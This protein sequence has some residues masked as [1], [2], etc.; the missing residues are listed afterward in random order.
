MAM[1][2]PVVDKIKA[3]D[4]AYFEIVG[5][6]NAKCPF[7]VTGSSNHPVG[8]FVEVEQ[9][10]QALDILRKNKLVHKDT[11]IGLYSWGEPTLHPEFDKIIT[12]LQ[13][14][15]IGEGGFRYAL[16]TNAGKTINYKPEW[17]R[18]LSYL[19]I[20]MC[21]FSQESY[22]RIHHLDFEK[23]K[24]NITALVQVARESGYNLSR[25]SIA[26][27]IYQFNTHEVP[28]IREFA[29]K[30]EI[31]Y[32]PYYAFINDL[33]RAE[34]YIDNTLKIADYKEISQN[35]FCYYIQKRLDKHPKNNCAQ[36]NILNLNEKCDIL[37]CCCLPRDHQDYVITNI[38]DKNMMQ[39]L[40]QWKPTTY[41]IKC[42]QSGLSPLPDIGDSFPYLEQPDQSELPFFALIHCLANKIV[43]RIKRLFRSVV[44]RY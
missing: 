36:F 10:Q 12:V 33:V 25:I 26:H 38:F 9:F 18:G 2:F 44:R 27:H 1:S 20:S 39:I 19:T 23:V 14:A 42:M 22:D 28:Q 32:N 40:G 29:K 3:Y 16:S 31:S 6:C 35:L 8:G 43:R 41:C 21:G 5:V 7:C 24:A 4:F 37:P 17:F 11:T 15:N 13:N 34:K 30:L